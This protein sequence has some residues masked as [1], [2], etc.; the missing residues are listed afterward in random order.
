MVSVPVRKAK[1]VNDGLV[2]NT[3]AMDDSKDVVY[4]MRELARRAPNGVEGWTK[5][6]AKEAVAVTSWAERN[7]RTVDGI[8]MSINT[9]QCRYL[10]RYSDEYSLVLSFYYVDARGVDNGWHKF[11]YSF[12]PLKPTDCHRLIDA[13]DSLI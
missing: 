10:E 2:S 1:T 13:F 5:Y 6:I 8:T 12:P 7:H 9:G 11:A 3:I 4:L